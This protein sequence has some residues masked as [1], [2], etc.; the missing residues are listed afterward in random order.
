MTDLQV[1]AEVELGATAGSPSTL[2]RGDWLVGSEFILT[3]ARSRDVFQARYDR[4]TRPGAHAASQPMTNPYAKLIPVPPI[5]P[6]YRFFGA[7]RGN[8][9]GHSRA[10]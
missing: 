5:T 9:V 10:M 1:A 4:K 6:Q 8:A 7:E 3:D 2:D